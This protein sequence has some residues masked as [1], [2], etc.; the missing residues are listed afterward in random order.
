MA[1][2]RLVRRLVEAHDVPLALLVAPA[3]YGKTALLAEWADHD[4]RPFAWIRAG[5]ATSASA[6]AGLL[7][8]EH[9]PH[10][11]VLVLDD[12]H[13]IRDAD[14]LAVLQH[15]A[16]T[17]PA[18]SQLVVSAREEPGLAVG[19]LR[20][21]RKLVELRS[22]DLSMDAA[23]AAALL[24]QV[25]LRLSDHD[26][27]TLVRRTEGWSAGLYLAALS[28]RAEPDARSAVESFAG[29][30][31][32]IADYLRDELL[33][34]LD[35]AQTAFLVRTSV[36]D[37]LSASACDAVLDSEGSATALAALAR[38]NTML[39][40]LN[41]SDETYR[42]HRLFG[43]MLRA[44]LRRTEPKLEPALHRR[45]GVWHARGG[46]AHAAIRHAVAAGDIETAAG[47]LWSEA[48]DRIAQGDSEEVRRWLCEFTPEQTA[49][50]APLAL[51]AAAA[52][53]AA[54]DGAGLER[55][56]TAAAARLDGRRS[57]V[58]RVLRDALAVLRSTD[59]SEGLAAMG[60]A[61]VRP[62]RSEPNGR[63]WLVTARLIQG[64]AHHL[65]GRLA[66][67]RRALEDGGRG[68]AAAA[69]SM[70]SLCLAQLYLLAL[71]DG[72]PDEAAV[73]VG[74]ARSQVKSSGLEHYP[75]S[76]LV[77]AVSALD[78]AQ[79]GLGQEA[80]GDL[81]WSRRLLALLVDFL[82][83]YEIE[84]RIVLA[85]AALCLGDLAAA[86]TLANEAS[87]RL[88][89]APDATTLRVWLEETRAEL[90]AATLAAGERCALTK[91]EVRVL[92]LLPTHLSVPAIASRLYVSPN[93]VKT[94]VRAV[95]RKL[96]ASSRAEAVAHASAAGLLDDAQ[97]A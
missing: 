68:G 47:V 85:R 13:A 79:R 92:Q 81:L 95:Y 15:A 21:H 78:R 72:N 34:P 33:A 12:A 88:R 74:R 55:W 3:G 31:R 43:E 64:V 11:G 52:S 9:G 20:A 50:H 96:D 35:A 44:E 57:G 6:L 28:V 77:F 67:A 37:T 51:A 16:E 87:G 62:R 30:D 39:V 65:T 61:A 5:A 83:W 17:M 93:T 56:T 69:P 53:L 97:A 66:D 70:Q 84:T 46:E 4:P 80:R 36:L 27:D 58:T 32:L 29:D 49:A 94:H 75:T 82:P 76:A 2:P 59:S 18:G 7:D 25:G 90:D 40:A 60:A 48:A 71:D 89:E 22:A 73:L 23:E 54:G 45:A 1:R 41:R 24:E 14:A 42:H 8:V 38:S 86:R 91:A 10:P 19:R 63:L 26:V